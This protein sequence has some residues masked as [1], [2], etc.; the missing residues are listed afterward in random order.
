MWVGKFD[1]SPL[2]RKTDIGTSGKL[3]AFSPS[4]RFPGIPRSGA[5]F[6]FLVLGQPVFAMPS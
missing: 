1:L 5:T 6:T 2:R 3:S 4:S